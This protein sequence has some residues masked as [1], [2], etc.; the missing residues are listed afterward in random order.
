MLPQSAR[1][2]AE[3]VSVGG[4]KDLGLQEKGFEGC[5]SD[6]KAATVQRPVRKKA[7]RGKEESYTDSVGTEA[8]K[9]EKESHET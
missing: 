4:K 6:G 1:A 7:S 8:R 2:G 3:R 5:G 9:D